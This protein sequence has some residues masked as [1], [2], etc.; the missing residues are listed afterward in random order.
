MSNL[1]YRFFIVIL[2]SFLINC[3]NEGNVHDT[4]IELKPIND[5]SFSLTQDIEFSQIQKNLTQWKSVFS[6]PFSNSGILSFKKIGNQLIS[7]LKYS[8]DKKADELKSITIQLSIKQYSP[9]TKNVVNYITL[10]PSRKIDKKK[11]P[12]IFPFSIVL[13]WFS[14]YKKLTFS[15]SLQKRIYD[16]DGKFHNYTFLVSQAPKWLGTID[17]LT[18]EI[19]SNSLI[20]LKSSIKKIIFQKK[21]K[22]LQFSYLHKIKT[23]STRDAFVIL[24]GC[25]YKA[26]SNI[27]AN[28]FL[29]FEWCQFPLHTDQKTTLGKC[30]L[31]VMMEE[32]DDNVIPIFDSKEKPKAETRSSLGWVT[33]KIKLPRSFSK[34]VVFKFQNLSYNP[35]QYR[36]FHSI[37]VSIPFLGGNKKPNAQNILLISIDT[38]RKDHLGCY[39]YPVMTSPEVDRFSKASSL[40]TDYISA[41]PSTT[42]AHG[43]M[44]TSLYPFVHGALNN[45]YVLKPQQPLVSDYL[46]KNGY[47]NFA[48]T[49]GAGVSSNHNFQH[50]YHIYYET[51]PQI[52]SLPRQFFPLLNKKSDR[53]FFA[54][55]HTYEVHGKYKYR[56]GYTEAVSDGNFNEF[57]HKISSRNEKIKFN[58]NEEK[59]KYL[60]SLYDTGIRYTDYYLG[61]LFRKLQDLNLSKNTIVAFTSDHGEHL[62]EYGLYGHS[63]SLYKELL[64]IPLIVK[65][66]KKAPFSKLI[67]GNISQS[68][69]SPT[70]LSLAHLKPPNWMKGQSY[71]RKLYDENVK[72]QPCL[73]INYTQ[74]LSFSEYCLINRNLKVFLSNHGSRII[75]RKQLDEQKN[76]KLNI[77]EQKQGQKLLVKLKEILQKYPQK[78]LVIE[79]LSPD[80]KTQ[81]QLQAL[82][83]IY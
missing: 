66:G 10:H 72:T 20:S 80:K 16:A 1:F 17:Y 37:A 14:S 28:S 38:L 52:E 69:L 70:L 35:E 8:F 22:R 5:T 81:E 61:K 25:I 74:N 59:A 27:N 76:I 19:K 50:G 46:L 64:T 30:H 51:N 54:F 55:F 58:N 34:K 12:N 45:Y 11:T 39:G 63:N 21:N 18:I 23:S 82:G 73:A 49:G 6:T 33:E 43:T 15:G 40:F 60:T 31:L 53:T 78:S 44:F 67:K 32:S 68:S 13:T 42:P 65:S 71:K 48:V 57:F 4:S 7:K 9:F 75:N 36:N 41:A 24:P 2:L 79:H 47:Y 62:G 77:D 83:Y 56:F 29:E 26:F 3:S